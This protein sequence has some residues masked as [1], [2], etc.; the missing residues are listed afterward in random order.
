[1]V[2]VNPDVDACIEEFTTQGVVYDF[3]KQPWIGQVLSPPNADG[4]LTLVWYSRNPDDRW[5]IAKL[6]GRQRHKETVHKDTLMYVDFDLTDNQRIPENV[7]N[8]CLPMLTE[9][10]H[11]Y[12]TACNLN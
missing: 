7:F 1:M 2:I 11:R 10:L 5:T 12:K 3:V 8:D 9:V 4:Y 6:D